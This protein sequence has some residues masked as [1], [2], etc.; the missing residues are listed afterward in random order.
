[1]SR[2][3]EV[4]AGIEAEGVTLETMVAHFEEGMS[5]LKTCTRILDDA[6]RRVDLV[7]RAAEGAASLTPF[8][9]GS[10]GT[11]EAAA[12]PAPAKRGRSA[13]PAASAEDGDEIRLF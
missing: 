4:V 6:Q 12:P 8:E 3:E 9:A 11:A 2:L 7:T 10:T 5:L 13:A 1:M